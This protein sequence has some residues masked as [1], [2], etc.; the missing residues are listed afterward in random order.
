MDAPTVRAFAARLRGDDAVR[1]SGQVFAI[2]PTGSRPP[3]VV[4]TSQ[5]QLYRALAE[6]LGPDQ[7]VLGLTSPGLEDLPEGFAVEDIAA[8]Q[9]TALRSA[10]PHG[11][12]FLGGWCVSGVIAYEMARQLRQQGEEVALLV[13][14]DTNSPEY[15]RKFRTAWS[16]PIRV[17]FYLE[18]IAHHLGV[19]LRLRFFD[20]LRYLGRGVR[21]NIGRW[22]EKFRRL[23]GPKRSLSEVDKLNLFSTLQRQAAFRYVTAPTNVPVVL[24]RSEV[25]QTGLFKDPALGW[26]PFAR[27]GL[28]LYELP[29]D[30]DEIFVEP[31]VKQLARNLTEALAKATRREAAASAAA[32]P[33]RREG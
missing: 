28:T 23:L 27:G 31:V 33:D 11:P 7:P 16:Y 12:Y 8:N 14:L 30:H 4:L 9:I 18:K 3:W 10:L 22:R 15:L 17:Y 26:I 1:P 20:K 2:R 25:L 5:P 13:L 21:Q 32:A 19:V 29:G 24:F 6:C